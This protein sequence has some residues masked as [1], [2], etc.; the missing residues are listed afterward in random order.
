MNSITSLLGGDKGLPACPPL[1]S[2]RRVRS[3]F[4][5]GRSGFIKKDI[6]LSG[7]QYFTSSSNKRLKQV[8]HLRILSDINNKLLKL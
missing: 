8:Q 6:H 3:R 5:E 4:G 1:H 7:F 2:G